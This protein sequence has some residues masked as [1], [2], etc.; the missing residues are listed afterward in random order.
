M[1]LSGSHEAGWASALMLVA[2]CLPG[3][4]RSF[5]DPSELRA[6]F[7]SADVVRVEA[8]INGASTT[9]TIRDRDEIRRVAETL[10]FKGRA[11][12]TPDAEVGTMDYIDVFIDNKMLFTL[13]GQL[14]VRFGAS[15][16]YTA[17]LLDRSFFGEM[18][19]RSI[20]RAKP[21]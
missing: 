11:A 12:D 5:P 3:C 18:L 4:A 14:H 9:F 6:A 20:S 8:T 1:D 19:S 16:M 15:N 21:G 17:V 13:I 7:A 2:V 10:R